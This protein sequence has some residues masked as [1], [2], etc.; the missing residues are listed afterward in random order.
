MAMAVEEVAS[1]AWWSP[2][3]TDNRAAPSSSSSSILGMTSGESASI[4]SV[5]LVIVKPK[6]AEVA[7]VADEADVCSDSRRIL[8]DPLE[9]AACDQAFRPSGASSSAM[10]SEDD[11]VDGVDG[12]STALVESGLLLMVVV[13]VVVIVVWLK[14]NGPMGAERTGD[15]GFCMDNIGM[16]TYGR[17][18]V[19]SERGE[20]ALGRAR[21]GR[22]REG[23]EKEGAQDEM[24]L[25]R[26]LE[27][28]SGGGALVGGAR[29]F[30]A[31][32]EAALLRVRRGRRAGVPEQSPEYRGGQ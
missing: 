17:A 21:R 10:S 15:G 13:F 14:R 22:E 32:K 26:R 6:V 1:A 23:E 8:S 18:N 20:A 16:P 25:V 11:G 29:V 19:W 12:L 31:A 28:S 30:S 7:E 9:R 5:A 27:D 4:G 3:L 24:V 2:V